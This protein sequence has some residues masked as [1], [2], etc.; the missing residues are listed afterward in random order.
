M[1]A[2]AGVAIRAVVAVISHVPALRCTRCV[3]PLNSPR[4]H[5]GALFT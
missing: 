5:Y 2:G 1:G 4:L 3:C